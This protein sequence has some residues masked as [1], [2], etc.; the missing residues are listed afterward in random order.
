VSS[1]NLPIT[2]PIFARGTVIALSTMT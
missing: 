1:P 2:L